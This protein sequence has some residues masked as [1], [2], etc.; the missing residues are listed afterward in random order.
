[1][2]QLCIFPP[3]SNPAETS[4]PSGTGPILGR[5]GGT[6]Y[7]HVQTCSKLDKCTTG[8]TPKP[9]PGKLRDRD[10]FTP[11]TCPKT[12]SP[13]AVTVE[14]TDRL[15]PSAARHCETTPPESQG[16]SEGPNPEADLSASETPVI[17]TQGDQILILLQH[18]VPAEG[19]LTGVQ[20]S[21]LPLGET[22]GH[23]LQRH[24]TWKQ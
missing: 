1:M 5:M 4:G 7:L 18:D 17:L 2:A 14:E 11:P 8:H 6:Q 20:W 9:L 13:R 24:L 22:H 23:L 21:L 12:S 3:P 10:G 15:S 16:A 19:S